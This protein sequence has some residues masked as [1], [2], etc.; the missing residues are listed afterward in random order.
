MIEL[1]SQ[2][3]GQDMVERVGAR[4]AEILAAEAANQQALNGLS[5]LPFRVFRE[6][7]AA[8]QD[9]EDA[10]TAT[11]LVNVMLDSVTYDP[12]A[13][14]GSA[15]IKAEARFYVDCYAAARARDRALGHDLADQAAAER[16]QTVATLV[17]RILMAGLNHRLQMPGEVISRFV[18]TATAFQPAADQR[19]IP[20][21]S[22]L[23]FSVNVE[24]CETAPGIVRGDLGA[25][26]VNLTRASDGQVIAVF[27]EDVTA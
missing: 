7:A 24:F 2:I 8:V 19:P 3:S 22:A 11:P 16:V 1:L 21:T 20:F 12:R 4:L 5:A 15:S 25:V 6:R 14:N 27:T 26:Q 18:S 23:R 10:K 9:F 13:S 17:R